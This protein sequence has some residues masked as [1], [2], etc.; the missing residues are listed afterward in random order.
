MLKYI[1]KRLLIFIP[2]LL[3]ISMV[4]FGLGKLAPGDPVDHFLPEEEAAS[5]FDYTYYK[6]EYAIQAKKLGLDKPNFYFGFHPIAYPD[7][8]Y[9]IQ[10]PDQRYVLNKLIGQYGNWPEINHYYQS[11]EDVYLSIFN[12]PDSI[13]PTRRI[14]FLKSLSPLKD[15]YK[16]SAIKY[17]ISTLEEDLL[18]ATKE[19][20]GA[21]LNKDFVPVFEKMKRAY[22]GVLEKATPQKLYRPTFQW[23]G[24]DNQYHNWLVN[25]FSG[26][27]GRSYQFGRSVT[28]MINDSV[29]WT[30]A[31]NL[32][33]I[34]LAFLLSIPLGVVSA[35]NRGKRKDRIISFL[36]F[37]LYSIPGFWMA[38]ML[39]VFFT[40]PEFG[41]KWFASGGTGNPPSDASFWEWFSTT[42]YHLILPIFCVT[43][44]ALAF[45]SRQIRGGM[46][47][48]INEDYVRTA[49]AKGLSERTV[50]WKHAFR[51]ALFPLITMFA[52]VFPAALA[53]SVVVEVIFNINGMGWLM[54]RSITAKDWPVVFTILMAM[55][56]LTM[57]G[58]LIADIL[59]TLVDPRVSFR[60]SKSAE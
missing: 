44:A 59:Y 18:A 46:L 21:F 43:Y 10:D 33:S 45:V 58:N 7:T 2:T 49:R 12:W 6:K 51:N 53:G 28:T 60:N 19:P 26:N 34:F 27:F 41:M 1:I 37:V 15:R 11:V 39:V 20:Y 24:L 14:G 52:V 4:V 57:L 35:V 3:V 30:L 23:Y 29:W 9:R 55:A 36:L 50:I 47:N 56:I 5:K 54:F 40:T 25:F 42:A 17:I 48:V 13:A 8:F 22:T 31:M 38:M 32:I 16:A